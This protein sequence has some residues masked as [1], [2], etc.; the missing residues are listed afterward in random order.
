MQP[1]L[2]P[3]PLT[4]TLGGAAAPKHRMSVTS[5]N[6]A[7]VIPADVLAAPGLS[8][9]ARLVLSEI[10]DLHKVSGSVWANDQ[11]FVNRL[12]GIQKRS[13]G[14]ALKELE[15]AGWLHRETNQ[16]AFHKRV[17]TPLVP[18]ENSPEPIAKSAISSP[19][20]LQNLQEPIAKSAI[21]L[22]QNLQEPIAN[23]ADIN[24]HL[25]SSRNSNEIHPPEKKMGAGISEISSPDL[26][27]KITAPTPVAVR[28]A[29]RAEQGPQHTAE[30]KALAAQIA[31]L[32]Y[33]TEQKN[34][35]RWARIARFVHEV[36]QA[37]QLTYLAA[38][39]SGY[40]QIRQLRSLSPHKL[41]DYLAGIW[42]ECDWVAKAKDTRPAGAPGPPP[43]P[44]QSKSSP[45]AKQSWS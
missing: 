1:A 18:N 33:V 42:D 12:P 37:G 14:G 30:T 44:Q 11:H 9:P 16:S 41:D 15:E 40:R 8:W 2:S 13:V 3:S 27:A 20:L 39:F 31:A 26:K 23:F 29:P 28:P 17:L 45:T 19:D 21:D 7:L 35:P 36:Q 38:Q 34:F 32:W 5:T 4:A 22:L 43:P 24:Y 6:R 25:N 10:L